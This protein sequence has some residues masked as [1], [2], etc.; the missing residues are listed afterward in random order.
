GATCSSC[1][2]CPWMSMNNLQNLAHVLETGENEIHVDEAVRKKA[3]RATQRMLE[4]A[5]N[6]A[7]NVLG[8][9]SA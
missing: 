6:Q 2:H 7:V 3:L 9:S 4:F 8:Q 1:A 5:K